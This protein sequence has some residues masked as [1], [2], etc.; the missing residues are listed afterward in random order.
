MDL[1]RSTMLLSPSHARRARTALSFGEDRWTHDALMRL[2]ASHAHTLATLGLC[3]GD[4]VAVWAR[5]DPA[6]VIALVANALAGFVS[7]PINPSV[8][9]SELAHVLADASPRVL[10]G[11]PDRDV[12]LPVVRVDLSHADAPWPHAPEASAPALVLYTSGTTGRPK[13]AVLSHRALAANLDALA[14]AWQW[15]ADDTLVH[16]LP[17]F[18]V[19]GLALGLFGALRAG[20]GLRL[21]P[22]FDAVLVRDALAAEGTMLFGV[23]TMYHRLVE[24]A[25]REA[26]MAAALRRARV[27]VSGSA[28]L[29]LREHRRIESVTG[30]GVFERY[31][32][33]ETLINT[34]VRVDEGP[35]PGYVGRALRGVEVRLVDDTRHTLDAHDD[36]TLGE[37]AVRGPNLFDGYLHR[38]DA[39]AAVRDDEGWFYTGD[40][41]A[42][43][44]DGALRIV[45]RRATDL[46]KTG[47]YKVGAGEVEAALLEHPAVREAAVKGVADDDLGE[48]IEAWVAL[49]EGASVTADALV[50]HVGASLAWHKRPRR[51]HVLEA[52]PRNAMGKVLKAALQGAAS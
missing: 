16:A 28:G 32:L 5:V 14:D 11:E 40:L 47:G 21:L 8:G 31:G 48:R 38:P 9:A 25:E 17:L 49:R 35:R 27:L 52:L 42:R 20:A 24:V 10:V 1:A 44:A 19:H 26:P 37:V 39:T 18:H 34:A 46:I 22:R 43:S 23:P 3:A 36:T 30:R 45:G 33:T 4:R 41:A 29:P 2:A 15:T 7:V 51:V 6:T 12:P 50:E 13:G